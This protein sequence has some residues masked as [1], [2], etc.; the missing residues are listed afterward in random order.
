MNIWL[1]VISAAGHRGSGTQPCNFDF[2][3]SLL[4]PSPSL[5]KE[6]INSEGD[7]SITD[8]WDLVMHSGVWPTQDSAY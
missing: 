4:C 3:L 7:G 1:R 6:C 5:R 8:K 2:F